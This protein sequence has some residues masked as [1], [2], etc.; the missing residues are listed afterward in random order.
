M[1]DAQNRC[2]W[3]G[4]Q[5]HIDILTAALLSPDIGDGRFTSVPALAPEPLL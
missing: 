4:G 2:R 5:W 3:N 1:D